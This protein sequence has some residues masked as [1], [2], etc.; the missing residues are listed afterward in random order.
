MSW[1]GAGTSRH[2]PCFDGLRAVAAL[3]IVGVHT[4]VASGFTTRSHLG[5]YAA[6]LEIGVAVFFLISGFLLYRPFVVA[7]LEGRRV[8]TGAFVRR[9]VLRIVPLYWCVLA[10]GAWGL[11]AVKV[12]SVGAALI[13]FGFVQIYSRRYFFRGIT[14]AWSLCTEVTYYLLLP[15][16]ARALTHRPRSP[17]AQLRAELAGT[18]LLAGASLAFRVLVI[19]LKPPGWNLML[20]W[21]PG[22]L[23]LFA[24]GMAL[25]VASVWV[26]RRQREP[27]LLGHP[28]MPW[29]AWVLAGVAFWAVSTRAGIPR[30]ALFTQTLPMNLSR[31]TL[32]GLFALFLLLPGVFG[33]QNRGLVRA[34]LRNRAVR[35]AGL[36]SYG[37][38]LWHD[39][40]IEKLIE[41]RHLQLFRIHLPYL[42]ATVTAITVVVSAVTYAVVERPFLSLKGHRLPARRE[43]EAL[44]PDLR[45]DVRAIGAGARTIG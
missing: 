18:G 4:A 39:V 42:F 25:A 10:V 26:E 20:N 15:L 3:S 34:L 6:R 31:Q 30:A 38:Y 16:Y 14:A 36:A 29:G 44:T 22:M 41:W 7:H 45:A 21:L 24:A 2:F 9:R 40:W 35:W 13:L 23:D 27:A 19:S 8:A 5:F 37:I 12:G 28:A 17:Q 11:H 32:Y 43:G 33:P 1:P